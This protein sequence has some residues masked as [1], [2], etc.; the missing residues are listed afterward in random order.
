MAQLRLGVLPPGFAPECALPCS[1]GWK[2]SQTILRFPKSS[3]ARRHRQQCRD[4][5]RDLLSQL[6]LLPACASQMGSLRGPPGNAPAIG[7]GFH[8]LPKRVRNT[9][10]IWPVAR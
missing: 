6:L 5:S 4:W 10:V 8:R 9:L 3:I 2:T 1:T 7:M